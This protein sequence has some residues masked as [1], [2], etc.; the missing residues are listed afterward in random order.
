MQHRPGKLVKCPNKCPLDT[1]VISFISSLPAL[2]FLFSMIHILLIYLICYLYPP[3]E[4]K[5]LEDGSCFECYI[6]T[7]QTMPG[8]Q[9]TLSIC[10]LSCWMLTEKLQQ[11]K[12]RNLE[13]IRKTLA[14]QYLEMSTKHELLS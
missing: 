7:P 13:V 10:C 4:L 5:F 1:R 3:V 8:N 14:A 9:Q 12:W 6:F 11:N 2:H